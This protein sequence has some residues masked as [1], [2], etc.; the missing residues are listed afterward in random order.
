MPTDPRHIPHSHAPPARRAARSPVSAAIRGGVRQRR[1]RLLRP[2][3]RDRLVSA[4]TA[5]L[6]RVLIALTLVADSAAGRLIV[7][8]T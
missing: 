2:H 6:D 3:L 1:D 4:H 7:R 5:L 8:S